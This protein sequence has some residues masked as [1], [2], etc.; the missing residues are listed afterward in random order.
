METIIA[1]IGTWG[2]VILGIALIIIAL[3]GS[4]LP[5]LPGVP[6]AG[7]AVFIIH[8]ALAPEERFS[9]YT[10]SFVVFISIVIS[11]VDYLLPIWGTKKYGGSK[12][13]I[14]GSTIGLIIGAFLSFFTAGIGI[15]ALFFGPFIGAYIGERYFAKVDKEIALKSA[16]GSLV[17]FLAGT[18]AKVVVVIILAIIFLIGAI[19]LI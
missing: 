15:L 9:W 19:R 11:A 1:T 7:L 3:I 6:F 16:W 14:K 17:G 4:V 12:E 18:L 13:G 2:L 5:A 10:L 8:F